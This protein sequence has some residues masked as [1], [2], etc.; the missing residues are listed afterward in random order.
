M[1]DQI[2]RIVTSLFLGLCVGLFWGALYG[3]MNITMNA[4]ILQGQEIFWDDWEVASAMRFQQTKAFLMGLSCWG[5]VSLAAYFWQVQ[6]SRTKIPPEVM[7]KL[8]K[9]SSK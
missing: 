3:W 8:K 7:A 2:R 6:A 5:G 1:D 9:K 4:D